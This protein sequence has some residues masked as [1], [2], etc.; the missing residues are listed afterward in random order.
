MVGVEA[1]VTLELVVVGGD[2]VVVVDVRPVVVIM[3]RHNSI[4]VDH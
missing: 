1:V 2:V 4:I 3:K